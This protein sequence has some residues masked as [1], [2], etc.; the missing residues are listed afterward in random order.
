[1]IHLILIYYVVNRFVHH[2]LRCGTRRRTCGDAEIRLMRGDV[3]DAVVLAR[4]DDVAVLQEHHPA[5]KAKVRVRPLVDLVGERHKD[6]QRVQV[7]VPRVDVVN[8]RCSHRKTETIRV[9]RPLSS[10]CANIFRQ[11]VINA[12]RGTA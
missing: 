1:M 10:V 9:Y 12:H 11:N 8:V 6:G 7:A 5:R 4:K 2:R 3:M